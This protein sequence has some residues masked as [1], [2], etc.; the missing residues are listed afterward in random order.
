VSDPFKTR[1][2]DCGYRRDMPPVLDVF[3]LVCTDLPA[4]LA[5]Y[6]RLGLAI[7]A[8]ADSEPHVEV[9]LAGGLRLCFDPASTIRSFDP[10][11]TAPSGSHRA[12][13]AFRCTDPGEVDAT[14]DD[15]VTA[16]YHGHLKP[17]DAFWG[18]RYATVLDPDGT[19]V[20]LYAPLPAT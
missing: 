18:Q 20:D 7:P 2:V 5:F 1:A 10:S 19:P 14:F 3:G 9:A 17:F 8:A 15:L 6:R 13:L 12:G 16:G 4:T 11:W